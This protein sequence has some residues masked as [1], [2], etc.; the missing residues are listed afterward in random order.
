M[1]RPLACQGHYRENKKISQRIIFFSVSEWRLSHLILKGIQYILKKSVQN[2]ISCICITFLYR[3]LLRQACN[4]CRRYTFLQVFI[5]LLIWRR[6][7][8]SRGIGIRFPT[9]TDPVHPHNVQISSGTHPVPYPMRTFCRAFTGFGLKPSTLHLT[10]KLIN[11][12]LYPHYRFSS[13][14]SWRDA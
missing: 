9:E 10:P 1:G 14:F 8:Y 11:T 3:Q 4:A 6:D 7:R 12:C 13:T 5:T 2:L